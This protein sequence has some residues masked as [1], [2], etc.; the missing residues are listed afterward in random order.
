M[1]R[2][3]LTRHAIDRIA[4][5]KLD[6]DQVLDAIED[7]EVSYPC[8]DRN[9]P[10]RTIFKKGDISVVCQLHTQAQPVVVS[11]LWNTTDHYDREPLPA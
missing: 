10:D 8:R 2:P 11:V 3:F 7:P 4:E 9:G 6:R 5:M 1:E